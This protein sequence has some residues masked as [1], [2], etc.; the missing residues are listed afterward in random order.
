MFDKLKQ[1][2]ALADL[3]KN[4]DKLREAGDRVREK[5]DRTQLIGV[6]GGGAARATVTG[7]MKVINIELSPGL[8]AGM[9]MDEK[10]RELAGSLIAD[11]VNDGL[12]QAQ[13]KLQE[14][15]G[16]EARAMGLDGLPGLPGFN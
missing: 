4:K 16:E 8:V 12:R 7:S 2:A 10:T 5:M 11:A 1:A 15:L 13:A 3:M 9:A 14:T 6:S